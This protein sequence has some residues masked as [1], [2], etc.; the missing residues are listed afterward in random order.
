MDDSIRVV[1]FEGEEHF[2]AG[3]DLGAADVR[4]RP[5]APAA[6]PGPE[7]GHCDDCDRA[8]GGSSRDA[9]SSELDWGRGR[10]SWDDC[11]PSCEWG[12]REDPTHAGP[13]RDVRG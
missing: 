9:A 12:D 13:R 1:I 10:V 5:P 8:S 4:N 3:D 11:P 2:S 7:V 6:E